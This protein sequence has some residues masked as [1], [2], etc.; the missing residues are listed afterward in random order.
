MAGVIYRLKFKQPGHYRYGG[1]ELKHG[2]DLICILPKQLSTPSIVL[3]IKVRYRDGGRG[4]FI[5]DPGEYPFLFD[6]YHEDLF[7]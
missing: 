4:T 2:P 6:E 7:E 3:G 1:Y 5:D